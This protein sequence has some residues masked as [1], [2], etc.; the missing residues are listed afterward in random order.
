MHETIIRQL[1]K[2]QC[3]TPQAVVHLGTCKLLLR[4]YG[5]AHW[6]ALQY[7]ERLLLHV[8]FWEDAQDDSRIESIRAR[9]RSALASCARLRRAAALQLLCQTHL[10]T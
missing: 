1:S 6:A 7:V 9:F 3:L 5:P 2:P 4:A 10:C 8:G